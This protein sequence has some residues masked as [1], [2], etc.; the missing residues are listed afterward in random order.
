[1]VDGAAEEACDRARLETTAVKA[2]CGFEPFR[3]GATEDSDEDEEL[4]NGL[5]L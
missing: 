2:R 3:R 4:T 1:M 5:G